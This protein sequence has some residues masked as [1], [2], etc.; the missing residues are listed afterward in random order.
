MNGVAEMLGKKQILALTPPLDILT[1]TPPLDGH[2]AGAG[3]RTYWFWSKAGCKVCWWEMVWSVDLG[4]G[5]GKLKQ[6]II[7][8]NI[9]K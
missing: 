2:K 7:E 6:L 5:L 4:S 1:L 9:P 8:R 3:A